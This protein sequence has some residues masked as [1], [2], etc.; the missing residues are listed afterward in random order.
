[1]ERRQ[2]FS[3]LLQGYLRDQGRELTGRT[4]VLL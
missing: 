3:V 2:P 1:M 4:S